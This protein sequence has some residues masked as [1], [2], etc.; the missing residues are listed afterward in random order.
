VDLEGNEQPLL[1]TPAAIN[2]PRLSP[3]GRLLAYDLLESGNRDVWVYDLARGSGTRLTFDPALDGFVIWTPN[4][5]WVTFRSDREGQRNIYRKRADGTGE[6]Q[7]LTQT[8]VPSTTDGWTPDGRTLLFHNSTDTGPDL[9]VLRLGEDGTPGK[10]KLFLQT[11]HAEYR[12]RFSP[13]GRWVA[14]QSNEAGRFE[15]YV[16]PFPA[17]EGRWQISNNGGWSPAW[18]RTRQELYYREGSKMMAV[19]YSA[20]GGSFRADP[21]WV[22]F[23][24]EYLSSQSGGPAYTLHPDGKR[25]LMMKSAALEEPQLAQLVFIQNFFDELRRI[26]PTD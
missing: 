2:R 24:G 11:A 19:T 5:R 12:A 17:G 7:Q 4:S 13:D 23:D 8:D 20:E 3:D 14:Y 16:R 6:V 18:S 21:P 25:F 22:L 15:L 10:P 1:D 26:M 9:W